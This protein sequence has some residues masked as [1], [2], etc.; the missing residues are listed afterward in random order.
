MYI[1]DWE[2]LNINN[3]IQLSRTIFKNIYGS[4]AM[5]DIYLE[6]RFIIDHEQLQF[7]KIYEW[8]SIGNPEEPDGYLLYN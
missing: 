5:Y 1:E 6:R 3:K 8:T 4:Q 2:K 7:D